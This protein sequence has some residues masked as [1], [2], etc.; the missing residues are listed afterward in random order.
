[1]LPHIECATGAYRHPVNETETETDRQTDR[2]TY[3][4]GWTDR[5]IV[6]GA[7]APYHR[8][9]I[10]NRIGYDDDDVQLEISDFT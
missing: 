1:M 10:L 7:Y 9:G 5:N 4:H 3:T 2:Q 8:V 6:I